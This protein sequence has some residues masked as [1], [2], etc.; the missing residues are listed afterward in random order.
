M[1]TE[2]LIVAGVIALLVVVTFIGLLS[3]YRKCASD[4]ILVV[5]GKAG[6]KKV[7]NEKTG[8]TEEVI[9]PSK[10]IHGGGTFVMPVIQDWAKMSL[11]PIQIQVM[12]EGVSSQM[13]K[14]RIPVTL[15][16]GIGTDQV[17]MQNA[18]SR[19][20]TA[21]TSEISD[22]IKD[23]LIGEVRSLMATMTIEEINADR[24]KF[25]GKA[26]ENIE[27]ELNKVGFSIIN[28]NNADI[29][30]DA[31]YIKNLGQKAATKALA[32]AQADIAEE[33]KKGDIQIA[34]TNKQREIAVADAEKERET[35][36]A[37]T[38]Q[39][40]EVK[41][42]EINQE[43]AI[44]LA[45]AEK[46]K[47]AGIA[48]QKAEQE[49]SIARA[50]TQAESAKAEAESQR[51]AN[52]AKSASE[53]AS[54][55]AAAD[56]EA[57]ANVAKA[58]AEA[59]SKK[60][61]A[62]AL[63]QT[64]IAQAKQKQEADTQK[65]INEQEAATAEYES[66]KRIK[67]AEADKQ[68]GVA[69]QKATIEVSKAKGEAAQAQAEAEKVAG[70]SKVEARMAV[71]KT[72]QERQI[73]VNEAAAKA[74]EAKLQ[75]EM[76]VPAQKQKERVTIEAEAIKAKAVLEA[77]AEAA[78]ILKEAE[79]KADATKLQLEAE[80]EGT[81]KKLLAEA[82][83]KRASL[84]AE[85]DKVQAIEMAPALAVEK[86]I[87]SGLTPEMVVQYKTVD[88]LTG[89]AEASA[90]MFEHVHLGQVTVYGNE[91]TA[92]NFMAKTAESL[93]PAFDLLRSIPFADTLKS[94]LG[95]KELE[96]KKAET[97]EFEEVK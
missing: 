65:A 71:A 21:K 90:Q 30:D 16:T 89:I 5:F 97:T 60:A 19:F 13:I 24:I 46:N 70:T 51:I 48:E 11:K 35:T 86:M 78:K 17:L 55:K 12:V 79:A 69:E 82:E 43:K 3:R 88:Q 64:R 94:V 95:K 84:M 34:E 7:V 75:A 91:N 15:T 76:I 33:K 1:T 57:E 74:E 8:K 50:N 56:A 25:I 40:Q 27:T 23:I 36:V 87:E 26:K 47:Q 59:D 10:I 49:A 66:Q 32:Q 77:E 42:A 72:E 31:N 67:A 52:V 63:K 62:E 93:N 92:G 81:R 41:V 22:Q 83:G 6:K 96:E 20:L 37:Q 39:E 9:L 85:A 45:E 44:R 54:K 80:A 68:A 53:A 4:E 61:E 18:A 2:T 28:I 38:K 73:E 14:V 58:K 29:S